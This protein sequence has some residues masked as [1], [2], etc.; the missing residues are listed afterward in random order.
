[1]VVQLCVLIWTLKDCNVCTLLNINQSNRIYMF[2]AAANLIHLIYVSYESPI[3]LIVHTPSSMSCLLLHLHNFEGL[4]DSIK[5]DKLVGTKELEYA[6][7]NGGV[8][9][10]K[11]WQN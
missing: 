7:C 10:A 6:F 8:W 1:M 3:W 11:L 4:V 5:L 2:V 9:L